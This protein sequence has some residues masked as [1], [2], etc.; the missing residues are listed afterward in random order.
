VQPH[1]GIDANL[2]AFW[3][4]LSQRIEA[5]A[6]ARLGRVPVAE[7]SAEDWERCARVSATRR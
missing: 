1:S 3:A 7:L 4:V 5:P 2:V 6:L